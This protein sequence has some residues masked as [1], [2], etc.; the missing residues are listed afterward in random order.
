MNNIGYSFDAEQRHNATETQCTL[1]SS[2]DAIV[3]AVEVA[4]YGDLRRFPDGHSHDGELDS[5]EELLSIKLAEFLLL[6]FDSIVKAAVANALALTREVA[7]VTSDERFDSDPKNLPEILGF[8][9]WS[10]S[11]SQYVYLEGT[12]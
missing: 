1:G 7:A 4:R 2:A 12:R 5:S 9:G 6:R 10:S 8:L 11:S 3:V